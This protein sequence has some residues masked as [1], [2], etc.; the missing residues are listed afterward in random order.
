MSGILIVEDD[1]SVADDL[2]KFLIKEGFPVVDMVIDA[3]DVVERAI[4][5]DV[6][7]IIMDINLTDR[8]NDIS[9][10]TLAKQIREYKQTPIIFLTGTQEKEVVEK[11]YKVSNNEF[12]SKPYRE[13]DLTAML[14]KICDR[15]ETVKLD[16]NFSFDFEKN[17]LT[18]DEKEIKLN[19]Q[20]CT[21]LILLIE[22]KN[23]IISKEIIEYGVWGDKFVKDST[24]VSLVSTL[25]TKLDGKFIETHSKLGYM[26]KI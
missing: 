7:L 4:K 25:R 8:T 9:G 13:F 17:I 18:K 15:S 26:F 24:R 16:A 2:K 10:I 19:R 23:K 11:T 21:L 6:K 12:L 22:N 20:L 1:Y 5:D 3:D 14:K